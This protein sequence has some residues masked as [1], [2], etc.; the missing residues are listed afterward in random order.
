MHSL[1]P[2]CGKF[3]RALLAH[4]IFSKYAF[5]ECRLCEL[6]FRLNFGK[7]SLKKFKMASDL[8]FKNV[9][10]GKLYFIKDYF[11]SVVGSSGSF[12][13]LKCK[14]FMVS[15]FGGLARK[16][17]SAQLAHQIFNNF[18]FFGELIFSCSEK[19]HKL[20]ILSSAS[21]LSFARSI[22]YV[23]ISRNQ[24]R[25]LSMISCDW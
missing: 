13:K 23:R 19:T 12:A 1:L 3:T 17:S 8:K 15:T 24:H 6:A 25:F 2:I 4:Q 18:L 14:N 5:W 7:M 16:Y 11:R 22:V 21:M 20:M 9:K 10:N